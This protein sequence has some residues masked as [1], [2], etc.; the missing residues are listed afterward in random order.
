MRTKLKELNSKESCHLF[1]CL[2]QTWC[3]SQIA[4]VALCLLAGCYGHAGD[5][6]RL[7]GEQVASFESVISFVK[8]LILGGDGGD[9]DRI[10]QAGPIVGVANIYI[11]EN[12]G[13]FY[14]IT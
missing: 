1:C 4:T 8:M 3:H 5:L 12:G 2:Y 13:E 9:V 14:Q 7:I 10:G 6:I 11:L